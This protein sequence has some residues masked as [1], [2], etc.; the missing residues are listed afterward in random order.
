MNDLWLRQY[1]PG[2]YTGKMIADQSALRNCGAPIYFP[3]RDYDMVL[4]IVSAQGYC[5]IT[6]IP[7]EDLPHFD[8][9]DH[10]AAISRLINSRT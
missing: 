2:R 1:R 8:S 6:E 3:E 10:S 7:D 5:L 9:A 4:T